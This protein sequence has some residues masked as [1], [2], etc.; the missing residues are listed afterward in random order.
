MVTFSQQSFEFI[1]SNN[2]SIVP[3]DFNPSHLKLQAVD[4]GYVLQNITG[5][6]AHI[7]QRLDGTG[8]D[9]AKRMI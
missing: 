5:I 4:D 9:I 1:L 8:Y 2:G 3:E 7:V 6:R